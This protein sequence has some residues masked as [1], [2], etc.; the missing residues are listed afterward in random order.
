MRMVNRM[1]EGALQLIDP[2]S[3][4]ELGAGASGGGA[5]DVV[6]SAQR[7]CVGV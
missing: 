4:S 6:R 1:Q 2:E 5:D 3:S 7:G